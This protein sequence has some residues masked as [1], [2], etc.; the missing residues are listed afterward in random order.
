MKIRLVGA[1]LFHADGHKDGH[2]EADSRFS[3]F[4]EGALNNI[5][6]ISSLVYSCDV[7]YLVILSSRTPIILLSQVSPRKFRIVLLTYSPS[8]SFQTLSN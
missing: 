3:Q 1:Q 5:H 6:D 2:D 7:R 4:C 8:D